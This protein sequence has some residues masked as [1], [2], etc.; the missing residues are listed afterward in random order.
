[1]GQ[2]KRPE[3]LAQKDPFMS[4]VKLMEKRLCRQAKEMA[5]SIQNRVLG[6]PC[7]DTIFG[8][9]CLIV[10][11]GNIAKELAPRQVPLHRQSSTPVSCNACKHCL[12][13]NKLHRREA[14]ECLRVD[15]HKLSGL[16]PTATAENPFSQVGRQ[17]CARHY[18]ELFR[19]CIFYS[20]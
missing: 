17:G 12:A 4:T 1:M 19:S 11:Y 2:R 9:T 10:G 8:K 3:H 13:T 20:K 5:A 7:G 6:L 16:S 14:S 15:M 18:L